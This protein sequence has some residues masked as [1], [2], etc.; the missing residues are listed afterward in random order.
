MRISQWMHLEHGGATNAWF[1]F[2]SKDRVP[3]KPELIL[4]WQGSN[5]EHFLKVMEEQISKK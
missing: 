1:S 4:V 3:S 2:T 5:G